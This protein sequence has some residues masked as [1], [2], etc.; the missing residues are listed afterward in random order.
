[1]SSS[2]RPHSTA[3]NRSKIFEP[4]GRQMRDHSSCTA[5]QTTNTSAK[6]GHPP[7]QPANNTNGA[8][9]TAEHMRKKR[10]LL[11]N[12]APSDSEDK[13][14]PHSWTYS[15]CHNG[16][17]AWNRYLLHGQNPVRKNR[18]NKHPK[19]QIQCRQV[20][21]AESYLNDSHLTF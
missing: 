7:S 20:A 10:L 11:R 2:S 3:S 17:L 9:T 19:I 12:P 18:A 4:L 6:N 13:T 15:S 8:K 1:M 16:D 5:M 21:R 14:K